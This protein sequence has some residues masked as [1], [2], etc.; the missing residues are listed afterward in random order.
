MAGSRLPVTYGSWWY[1]FTD[2]PNEETLF[3]FTVSRIYHPK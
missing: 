1:R 2:T 3:W